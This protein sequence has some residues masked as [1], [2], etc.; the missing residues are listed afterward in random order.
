[1]SIERLYLQ[2]LPDEKLQ[3]IEETAYR[4]LE[5]VGISL[6]HPIA[7]EMLSGLGCRVEKDRTYMPRSVVQRTLAGITSSRTYYSADGSRTLAVGDGQIRTHNGGSYPFILDPVT[8]QRRS[9]VLEDV[10]IA[11]RFLDALPN[12]DVVIPL[13]GPQD[14]PAELMTITAYAATVKNTRKP[15]GLIAGEKPEEVRAIAALAAACC[16]GEEAFRKRPTLAVSI[17]PVSPLRFNRDCI[18]AIIAIAESGAAFHPLPAPTLGATA[19]ISMAGAVAQQHAETIASYVIAAAVRP[20]IAVGYCSRIGPIDLRTAVTAWGNPEAGLTGAC[21][22]QLGHRLGLTC[23]TYG[24]CTQSALCDPQYSYEKFANAIVPALVGTDIL[25]GIASTENIMTGSLD[26]AVIDDEMAGLIKHVS[27]GCRVDEDTL[28]F[29]VMKDVI[30]NGDVFLGQIHT[31][32]QM[33][34]GAIWVPG[35]SEREIGT[36]EDPEFG[37]IART[38]RRVKEIMATHHVEPLPDDVLREIDDILARA[39]RDLVKD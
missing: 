13:Y 22:T 6:D 15:I 20:D 31:V 16:G 21:A 3:Q 30:L 8:G 17:S 7:Q 11:A 36:S 19:P 39:K 9:P 33:R 10:A 1:M 2:L 29:D 34:Q 14:V 4:L 23:D 24:F 28:A 27:G 18:D 38:R 37:V 25:S 12:V 5:E 32:Q 35:I 26:S